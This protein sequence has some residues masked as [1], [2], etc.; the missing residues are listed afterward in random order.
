MRAIFPESIDGDLLKLIHLSNGF[1]A[2]PSVR[3]LKAGDVCRAEAQIV[4]V[5]NSDSGKRVKVRGNVLRAS[6]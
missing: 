1:R 2:L 5:I 3:P 6:L 4:S